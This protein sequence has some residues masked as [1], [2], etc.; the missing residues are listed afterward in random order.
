M[1]P[2]PNNMNNFLVH[3]LLLTIFYLLTPITPVFAQ[4][5]SPVDLDKAYGFGWINSL[6][7]ATNRLL[8]PLFAIALVVVTIYLIIGGLRF[9]LSG[10]DKEAIAKG[11]NMITH[12]I[13]GLALLIAVFLVMQF[14]SQFFGLEGFRIIK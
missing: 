10:G 14:L 11:K 4:T 1:L 6:A 7:E 2:L 9:L 3:L 5:I 13:I 8:T 12:S